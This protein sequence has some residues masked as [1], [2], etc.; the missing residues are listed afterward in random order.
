MVVACV[1]G[2][3]LSFGGFGVFE[4]GVYSGAMWGFVRVCGIWGLFDGLVVVGRGGVQ[5]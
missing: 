2:V 5:G 3:R 1:C 4:F